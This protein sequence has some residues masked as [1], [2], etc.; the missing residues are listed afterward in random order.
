MRSCFTC[1]SNNTLVC[2]LLL[3]VTV[4][5]DVPSFTAVTLPL[6]FIVATDFLLEVYF[7]AVI[8]PFENT[9]ATFLLELLHVFFC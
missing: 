5:V 8:L 4:M 7:F 9:V 6:L 3:S 1:Y 2:F